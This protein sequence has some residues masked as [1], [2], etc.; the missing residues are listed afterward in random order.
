MKIKLLVLFSALCLFFSILS[1]QTTV[2]WALST[3]KNPSQV[4]GTG[5]TANAQSCTLTT[6]ST[7]DYTAKKIDGTTGAQRAKGTYTSCI[8]PTAYDPNSYLE[9]NLTA[10]S[11]YNLTVSAISMNLGGS[12]TAN[13]R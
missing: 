2:T 12:G 8:L 6:P 9:Y 11:G 10:T 5:F 13:I 4:S 7:I 3:D 1:A